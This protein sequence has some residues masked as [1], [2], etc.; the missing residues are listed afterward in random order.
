MTL[1]QLKP[2]FFIALLFTISCTSYKNVPYFNDLQKDNILNQE[3]KNY[4]Q[5]TIQNGDI[6]RIHVSSLN[7]EVD[8]VFNYD[9]N[10]ASTKTDVPSNGRDANT[11]ISDHLVDPDG[12]VDLPILGQVKVAGLTTQALVK[13]LESKLQ[14]FFSKPV[15]TVRIENF[16]ISVLGDV[17]APGTYNVQDE[18]ITLTQ[19]ISLAGDLNVTGIRNNVLLMREVDGLRDYIHI[20]LSSKDIITS[21]Y[22]YLK[23]ND[24]LYVQPNR[25]KAHADNTAYEKASILISAIS[26]I[27]YLIKYK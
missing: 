26:I 17:R 23:N 16:K 3:I 4:S 15:V 18:K 13:E 10:L 9:L 5:L 7:P 12:K 2:L 19:A 27:V 24:V 11:S 21:P 8:F 1:K 25:V 6:L 22:W 14:N 20:D